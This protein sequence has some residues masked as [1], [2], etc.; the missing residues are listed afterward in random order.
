[1]PLSTR[2][3]LEGPPSS[4]G[5]A[6]YLDRICTGGFPEATGLSERARRTWFRNYV[7]TVVERDVTELT[8]ARRAQQLPRILALLTAR[9]GGELVVAHIHSDS[10]LGSRS[11]TEDYIAYLQM[12][13]LVHLLPAWSRNLTRKITRHPKVHLVDTGLA[14]QV[15]GKNPASL[16]RP[17]DPARGPLYETFVL[18][19]LLRQA[20]W[21]DDEI[22]LHHLRDRDGVEVDI[23]AEAADGR[24]VAF[25][26]KAS[27]AV[28]PADARHLAWLR[29]KIGDDFIAGVVLYA[30]ERP[31]TL[32]DRLLAL[33]LSYLWLAD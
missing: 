14:A 18:N 4:I 16:S 24:V 6:D 12:T 15:L 2:G 8:G 19:E 26:A 33:P 32:G 28:A 22:R 21:L 29:D 20:G 17:A 5:S 7:R 23:V 9:T 31:F 30:G 11:T 27:S 25:E 3:P 13:Y 1:M 10:G